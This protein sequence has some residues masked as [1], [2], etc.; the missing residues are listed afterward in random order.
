MITASLLSLNQTV[1]SND[2]ESQ[3]SLFSAGIIVSNC[4]CWAIGQ[5]KF[6]RKCIRLLC[7]RRQRTVRWT[8][9]LPII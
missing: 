5:Y 9:V 4:C 8:E 7:F 6:E 3:S 1:Q 2:Q